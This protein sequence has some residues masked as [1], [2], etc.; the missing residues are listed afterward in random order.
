MDIVRGIPRQQLTEKYLTALQKQGYNRGG[1]VRMAD[2]GQVD[3]QNI[4]VEEAPDMDVKQYFMPRPM[5]SNV[6]PVGG[7]QQAPMQP[8]Q[9]PQVPQG[10]QGMP[11]G[12]A[13][14]QPPQAP[15]RQPP[16]NILQMT[17][18]GQAMS[19]MT[20]PKPMARGGHVDRDTMMLEL[21]N[22]QAGRR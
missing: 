14:F 20:P 22:R 13:P 19:A 17:P 18:Q 15:P 12:Q 8:Q 11:Q 10:Q 21:M 7:I 4:G 6:F 5:T 1:G 3:I 9:Q 16:S 2:G